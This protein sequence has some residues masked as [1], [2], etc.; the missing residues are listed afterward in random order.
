MNQPGPEL[1]QPKRSKKPLIIIGFVVFAM[2]ALIIVSLVVGKKSTDVQEVRVGSK[3]ASAL[4][5]HI[6]NNDSEQAYNLFQSQDAQDKVWFSENF[7]KLYNE[8]F[9]MQNC[10][11][12]QDKYETTDTEAKLVYSCPF[13]DQSQGQAVTLSVTV[14]KQTN[15]VTSVKMVTSKT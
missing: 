12:Q 13:K 5:I 1:E 11:E 3:E 2:L 6:A 8:R 9:D 10:V 14:N 4:F 15:K 7:V